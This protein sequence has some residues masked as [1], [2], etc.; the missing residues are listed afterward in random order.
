MV[1]LCP[2]VILIHHGQLLYDGALDALA[3][4]LAPYKLVRVTLSNGSGTRRPK[5]TAGGGRPPR[6]G[7]RQPFPAGLPRRCPGLTAYLLNTYP[8]TDLSVENPPIEAV[9][10]PRLHRGGP[11]IPPRRD[12]F[13]KKHL[14]FLDAVPRLLLCIGV[15]LDGAAPDLPAVWSTAAGEGAPVG[16]SRGE[17]AAYYLALI[18]VNQ[19]T[20]P[21][22]NWTVGDWIRGGMLNTP[23]CG[24]WPTSG[25]CG[26]RSGRQGGLHGLCVAGLS[27]LAL[28][29]RPE[30]CLTPRAGL[31]FLPALALAWAYASCGGC[32]W[33]CWPSGPPAPMP[34]WPCRTR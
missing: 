9:H 18:V 25:R 32:G 5:S 12:R 13:G 16:F 26:R 14:G 3:G 15:W 19:F 2:R 29:L 24:P 30:L 10:R 31:L 8:V 28:V 6:A 21:Q 4:R 7:K 33:R 23:C 1:T 27:P 22:T 20:Y 17:F 11:M 34:S